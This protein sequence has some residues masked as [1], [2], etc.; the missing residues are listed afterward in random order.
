MGNVNKVGK[1]PKNI[2]EIRKTENENFLA[3]IKNFPEERALLEELIEL[4]ADVPEALGAI[5]EDLL[6][7]YI[8]FWTAL[9]S[10]IVGA[11][12][13][14]ETHIS[15]ALSLK[16]RAAEATG[17]ANAIR[18]D[19]TKAEIW[20]RKMKGQDKD[21]N[22]AFK[23]LFPKDDPVVY[24]TI[25][26]IYSE[27]REHGSHSNLAQ[28]MFSFEIKEGKATNQYHDLKDIELLRWLQTDYIKEFSLILNVFA[29][30]FFGKLPVSWTRRKKGFDSLLAR[31]LA[32]IKPEFDR[33]LKDEESDKE[34]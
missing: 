23:P 3:S 34:S 9:R 30:C 11:Q 1:L 6:V 14:L 13:L 4:Y 19:L 22:K 5:P 12:L 20:I 24:P 32:K 7:Q 8:L 15:E 26:S 25:Y 28:A 21:F 10:L 31:H 29:L 2:E 27:T 16:S 33:W 18:K 17:Y